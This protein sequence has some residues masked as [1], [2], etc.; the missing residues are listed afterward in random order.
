AFNNGAVTAVVSSS[1]RKSVSGIVEK[2]LIFVDDTLIALQRLATWWRGKLSGQ[3][4]AVT[5]SNGKT[6]LK[7]TL[8]KVLKYSCISSIGSQG[9]FNSQL[10]V[11]L[12]VIRLPGKVDVAVIEAGISQPG[13][14]TALQS[15]LRPDYGVLTNIGMA[16]I[17]SF[18]TQEAIA[19]EKFKLFRDIPSDGW[20]LIPHNCPYA[21]E[22]TADLKCR[23][24][25]YGKEN[26]ELPYIFD[27]ISMVDGT[28]L[29]IRFPSGNTHTIEVRTFSDVVILDVEAAIC[30][31][32]MLGAK[33]GDIANSLQQHEPVHTRMEIWHSPAGITLV[34]DAFGA[35][36][37]SVQAALRTLDHTRIKGDR[38]VF[39]FGGMQEL[40]ELEQREHYQ[41]GEIAAR[42]GIELLVL[43]GGN[44][45][46][47][48]ENAFKKINPAG[49]V[50][51]YHSTDKLARDLRANLR[52]NDKVL[53]K[54]PQSAGIDKVAREVV[55]AMAYNRLMVDVEA[56][57]ENVSRFRQLVGPACKILGM[58]KALAYGSNLVSL[59]REIQELGL[60]VL[61]VSTADEGATLR[62]AGVDLPILVMLCTQE[63]VS[64]VVQNYLT[65][66]IYS[67]DLVAPLANAA[68]NNGQVLDVHLKVD[69]GMGRLGV[70]PE[71]IVDLAKLVMSNSNLRITGLMT[72]FACAE[73]PLKD[74]FNY[75]QISRFKEAISKLHSL[76]LTDITCHAAATAGAVRFPEARFDMVRIGL[77]LHGLYPGPAV[78]DKIQL[79]LA[80][81]LLSR[82]TKINEYRKGDRIGYGG[83][84]TVPY[85]K[86]ITGVIPMGYNDGLPLQLSNRG[87]VLVNGQKADI[88]GRISMDSAMIDLNGVQDA[89][90]GSDVL[91]FGTHNGHTLRPEIVAELSDTIVYEIL[92]RLG[93]RIQRIFIRN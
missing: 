42:H 51:R 24:L 67:F 57:S 1:C 34:N 91:I 37:I 20:L 11:P 53:F 77:G 64:K 55:D 5:G 21:E 58:V 13:E 65:P 82:I 19:K 49:Q 73:D 78:K 92:T 75:L 43:V 40:G 46:D 12:S 70:S 85:D 10:G 47:P 76:G 33:A 69:T 14:M 44:E 23:V 16:H 60:D 18:G 93:S 84:F 15:I 50:L 52:N 39:V 17:A 31:A 72:H 26:A 56:L 38:G 87:Y 4:L 74:D 30:A 66:V 45:L 81:T 68:S 36:P 22:L 29:N 25:R 27:R 90:T 59:S 88:I 41:I 80:V 79:D 54:G 48:T 63:E 89:R 62:S 3:L 9:S 83:T 28:K 32:Y 6:I 61:G 7:D 2:P 86:F 8:V 71:E 35:D